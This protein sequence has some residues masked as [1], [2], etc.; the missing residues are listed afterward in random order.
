MKNTL[1][2]T[3]KEEGT[4]EFKLPGADSEG[5]PKAELAQVGVLEGIDKFEIAGIKVG[6]GLIGGTTALLTTSVVDGFVTQSGF[7]AAL[8]KLIAAG[9]LVQFGSGILG[10]TATTY[11]S[12][13]IAFDV[14]RTLIPLDQWIQD[15][16]GAFSGEQKAAGMKQR[17]PTPQV[18]Q[19][20]NRVASD[21]YSR[22]GGGR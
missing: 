2:L 3:Q 9:G 6:A 10:K 7:T 12:A 21:Y 4:W 22:L 16:M 18:I 8:I 14:V 5:E 15:L 1:E 20:A 17:Q 11:A 19:E 13:F